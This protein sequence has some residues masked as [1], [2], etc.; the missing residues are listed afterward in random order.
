MK[1]ENKLPNYPETLPFVEALKDV[2]R[3]EEKILTGF[4]MIYGEGINEGGKVYEDSEIYEAVFSLKS[5]VEKWIGHT[6]TLGLCGSLESPGD[7]EF[8]P[9]EKKKEE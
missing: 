7:P 5:E 2:I 3:A 1:K 8:C 6:L 4:E 9:Q